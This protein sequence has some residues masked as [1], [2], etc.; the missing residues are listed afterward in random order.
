[1]R[2]C[3]PRGAGVANRVRSHMNVRNDKS[4]GLNSSSHSL[5]RSR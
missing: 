5:N 2:A 4:K 3:V 1:M